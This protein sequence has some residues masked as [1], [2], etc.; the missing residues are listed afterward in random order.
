MKGE[1]DR[2]FARQRAT[3]SQM[4]AVAEL[5]FGDAE[6]LVATGQVNRANGAIYMAGLAVEILLKARLLKRHPLLA[7]NITPASLD[8]KMLR[9]WNLI[10]R[11]H[12]LDALLG[13]L[14]ELRQIVR[15][16][17]EHDGMPYYQWLE[18]VCSAWTINVRYSSLRATLQ[19]ATVMTTRVRKLKELLK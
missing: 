7:Q 3:V 6:A 15:T 5:R 10:F 8:A 19:D 1:A 18:N 13:E 12:D 14:T 9:R 16:H 11:F 2:I 4:I 17:G